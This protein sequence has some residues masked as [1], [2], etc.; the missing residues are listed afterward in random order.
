VDR[1]LDTSYTTYPWGWHKNYVGR[2]VIEISMSP[3]QYRV[4]GHGCL[5][6]IVAGALET[7]GDFFFPTQIECPAWNRLYDRRA[8]LPHYVVRET[9]DRLWSMLSRD[10][11][12]QPACDI[13]G[14]AYLYVEDTDG[15]NRAL[16]PDAIDLRLEF[17]PG[18]KPKARLTVLTRCDAWLQRTLDGYDNAIVGSANG[19][20]LTNQ[21]IALET[22]LNGQIIEAHTD[23]DQVCIDKY[24][25]KNV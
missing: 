7:T 1:V 17:M 3:E 5:L 2:W 23:F 13:H 11:D 20:V 18:G 19:P 22:R 8:L 15:V 10:E 25:L 21:L 24:H 9:L 4:F 14:V 16:V 6:D 12:Y